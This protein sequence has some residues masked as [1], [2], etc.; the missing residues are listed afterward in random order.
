LYY[1]S[2]EH[3][4]AGVV[5]NAQ[6]DMDSHSNLC[7]NSSRILLLFHSLNTNNTAQHST[8]MTSF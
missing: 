6:A 1:L 2:S 3:R 7:S 4:L 5:A 8:A